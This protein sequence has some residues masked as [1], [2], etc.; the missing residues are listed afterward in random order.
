[1]CIERP[2]QQALSES[3]VSMT[4]YNVD[5]G[6]DF[7][8]KYGHSKGFSHEDME[9]PTRSPSP[10]ARRKQHRKKLK[11]KKKFRFPST[12]FEPSLEKIDEEKEIEIDPL[13]RL[14]DKKL[15][16]KHRER[17]RESS[18]RSTTEDGRRFRHR[19]YIKR[20]KAST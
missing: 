1:M 15:S 17:A 6:F 9:M 16:S 19:H 12:F 3:P 14:K 13:L 18:S 5:K 10:R 11:G 7:D 20:E 2:L 8:F 4:D